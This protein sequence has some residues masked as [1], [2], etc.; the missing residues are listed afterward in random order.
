MMKRIQSLS[1]LSLSFKIS[2]GLNAYLYYED[3]V[4]TG[5]NYISGTLAYDYGDENKLYG[6]K[7]FTVEKYDGPCYYFRGGFYN[8]DYGEPENGL[9]MSQGY[10]LKCNGAV[11]CSPTTDSCR[12]FAS[13]EPT[14]SDDYFDDDTL[15][16]SGFV[17][18]EADTAKK[19]IKSRVYASNDGRPFSYL[20]IGA[21][22]MLVLLSV[23]SGSLVA[24]K[25]LRDSNM[26]FCRDRSKTNLM[27]S[28][29]DTFQDNDTDDDHTTLT[30]NFMVI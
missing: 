2:H 14:L 10:C 3:A 29:E 21:A 30:T 11:G 23:Y 5:D 12:E 8:F 7:G 16:Y 18:S 15:Y 20:A 28:E 19:L 6:L 22:S 9:Y 13:V 26:D 25:K 4:C 27:G 24:V 17:K 1:I